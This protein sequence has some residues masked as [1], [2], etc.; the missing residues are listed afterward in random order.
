MQ[1]VAFPVLVLLGME[2]ISYHSLSATYYTCNK[3]PFK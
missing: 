3:L 1:R 2:T